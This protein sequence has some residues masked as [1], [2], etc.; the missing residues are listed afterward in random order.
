[1]TEISMRESSVCC[2]KKTT[3]VYLCLLEFFCFH[4]YFLKPLLHLASHIS[5]LFCTVNSNST[6]RPFHSPLSPRLT[7]GRG[8]ARRPPLHSAAAP[9]RVSHLLFVQGVPVHPQ[10]RGRR[11]RTGGSHESV[12]GN[13]GGLRKKMNDKQRC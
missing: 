4:S 5:T 8:G 12:S 2:S 1:V 9:G 6:N 3:L 7:G 13:A 10:H 11:G